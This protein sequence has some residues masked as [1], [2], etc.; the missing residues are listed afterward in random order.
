MPA[1]AADF[2][3]RK[4]GR[5][6]RRDAKESFRCVIEGF[7]FGPEILWQRSVDV[8]CRDRSMADANSDLVKV[9]HDVSRS[10]DATDCGALM[11]VYFKIPDIVRICAQGGR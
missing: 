10:I 11:I 4:G 3:C 2:A 1:A 5:L 9:R 8:S 6:Q 7:L